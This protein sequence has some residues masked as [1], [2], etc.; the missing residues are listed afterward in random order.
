MQE[1]L[2]QL[3][4][5]LLHVDRLRSSMDQYGSRLLDSVRLVI[6]TCLL[7]YI[8]TASATDLLLNGNDLS[9]SSDSKSTEGT[10]F[11]QRVRGMVSEN[12]LAC[13]SMCY[14]SLI[15]TIARASSV[16]IFLC[17]AF[18]DEDLLTFRQQMTKPS[19]SKNEIKPLTLENGSCNGGHDHSQPEE[20]SNQSEQEKLFVL[21]SS[22]TL[23]INTCEQAQKS[24][25]Q[26]L[27]MRKDSVGNMT[28]EQMKFFWEISLHFIASI[29]QLKPT[30]V[31]L[32]TQSL[33]TGLFGHSK[34]FLDHL[35]ESYKGKLVNTLDSEK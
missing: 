35:H 24:V 30:D 7:E 15:Q 22:A 28:L 13:L 1:P 18:N 8:N 14:E 9:E 25:C 33:R 3:L 2:G 19:E 11:A 21:G 12:F 10:P 20:M 16:H 5:A 32:S 31:T 4:H 17:D 29:E 27:Q 6:V 23:L 26:L 34:R